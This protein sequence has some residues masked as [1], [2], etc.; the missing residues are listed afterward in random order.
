MAKRFY[1][2]LQDLNWGMQWEDNFNV[3]SSLEAYGKT[4]S[5]RMN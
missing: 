3:A 5:L 2:I 4:R 1:D